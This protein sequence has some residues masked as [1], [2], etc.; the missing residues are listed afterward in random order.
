LISSMAPAPPAIAGALAALELLEERPQR[1]RQLRAHAR[2]L[3]TALAAEGFAV[4]ESEMQIV[5]LLTGEE[6]AATALCEAALRRGVFAQ[7]IRPPSV[8]AGTSRLRLTA[9]ATHTPAELRRAA[10]VLGEVAR[11][12]GL[13]PA[14]MGAPAHDR[15]LVRAA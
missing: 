5:P 14:A 1:V 6:R 4:A 11:E 3:R 7:A 15:S 13:D 8:P 10:R 2:T 9:M 12:Q